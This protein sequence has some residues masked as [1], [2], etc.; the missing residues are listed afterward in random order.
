MAG[1][2]DRDDSGTRIAGNSAALL[3][4]RA[5]QGHLAIIAARIKKARVH[6]TWAFCAGELLDADEGTPDCGD[7]GGGQ[8]V[9]RALAKQAAIS[10]HLDADR[11]DLVI[12]RGIEQPCQ[13]DQNS[14][15]K[16][17]R[18]SP[19]HPIVDCDRKI[20]ACLVGQISA[21]FL[22]SKVLQPAPQTGSG[23]FDYVMQV[24]E[25]GFEPLPHFHQ[26]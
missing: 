22:S 25:S 17:H 9:V 18:R 14:G 20:H 5:N 13:D 1:I 11:A 24:C 3:T 10:A 16:V 8:D 15:D 4:R 19:R 21:I 12:A 23:L 26:I 7:A 2:S 6:W